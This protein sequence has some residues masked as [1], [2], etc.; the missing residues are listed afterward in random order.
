M[1][2][3][4][5]TV[6]C[7]NSRLSFFANWCTDNGIE[8]INNLGG[9][10]IYKY[11]L[12]RQDGIN[13]VILK[14]QIDTLRVFLR[15]CVSIDAVHPELPDKVQSP[16]LGGETGRRSDIVNS[17][18]ANQI[19]EYLAKYE[20]CSLRHVFA[21]LAWATEMRVGAI[22]ALDVDDYSPKDRSLE[23]IHRA[24]TDTPIKNQ[25][26]GERYVPLD[27]E[28]VDLIDD[29]IENQRPNNEDEYGRDPLLTTKFGRVHLE[30]LRKYSYQVTRP[31]VYSSCPHEKS[32]ETCEAM[33]HD[34]GHKCPSSTA[35]HSWRRGHITH[36]LR[37]D[38]PKTV[39]SDR[40]NTSP[41]VIDKHYDQMTEEEKME[42][43]RGYLDNI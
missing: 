7:H 25:K 39:V 35:P 9:R 5:A 42:Q 11:K 30:T 23:V 40:V 38:T 43:R 4:D 3:A 17:K 24:E 14:G 18:K 13:K 28:T 37:E 10:D 19:L 8:N 20:Y 15:F 6:R 34:T 31:C 41:D 29:W 2:C 22:H 32:P 36:L 21:Q 1:D 33:N 26:K 27:S 12:W 16:T